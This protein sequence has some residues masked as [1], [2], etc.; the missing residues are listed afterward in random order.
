MYSKSTQSGIFR[1]CLDKAKEGFQVERDRCPPMS[2]QQ[3][4][5]S[6]RSMGALWLLKEERPR[7]LAIL[8]PNK[9]SGT[10]K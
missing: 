7:F 10:L 9:S 4:S 6:W 1:E 8:Q 2:L 3:A 5:T